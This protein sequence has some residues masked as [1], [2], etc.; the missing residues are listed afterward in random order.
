MRK[1][2]YVYN[3]RSLQY[4]QHRITPKQRL[5]QVAG[6]TVS[7][8][9]FG[10]AA[11]WVVQQYFPTPKEKQLNR[12]LSNVVYHFSNLKEDFKEVAADVEFLQQKDADIH[13]MIFGIDPI[14]DGIWNGGVG[15]H[16]P[17][18]N[19]VMESVSKEMISETLSEVDQLKRK[20]EIQKASLDTLFTLAVEKEK[21]L[22][23]IPS[24]KPLREDKL[25]RRLH[26]LSGF[27]MRLHPVHKVKKFH[28]GIDFT[29]PSGTEI[30]AT[31]NGKV[32]KIENKKGGYGRNIV[33]DHGYGY[34]TLYGH[35]SEILVKVGQDVVKG[36]LIGKV[37]NTGTSTAPHLHY[38]VR[39]NGK[40]VNPIDYCMD[41]LS[42]E[43]YK[44]LVEL[45]SIKNQSF[46]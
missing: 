22:A 11:L 28:A 20:I 42:P 35:M 13:R 21:R 44:D 25:K 46:D 29:A 39:I 8:A 6:F 33:I 36:Q 19:M 24:I 45:A 38:E 10:L 18:D 37:G 41:G 12:Q 7:S 31:G 17:Y 34:T 27:G 43:E 23:S 26:S 5:K 16:K 40:P 30:Q 2:K 14:D 32:I 15:G 4:E 3:E 9:L 1:H